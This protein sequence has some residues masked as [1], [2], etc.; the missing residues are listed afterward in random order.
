MNHTKPHNREQLITRRDRL[1][2]LLLETA[3]LRRECDELL[4]Y[5][6]VYEAQEAVQAV[7][8]RTTIYIDQLLLVELRQ[9]HA[10]LTSGGIK[11]A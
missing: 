3:R 9:L 10:N 6:N 7:S 2:N 11:N 1:R 5:V 8:R 4:D